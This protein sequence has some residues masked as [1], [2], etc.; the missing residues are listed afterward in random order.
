LQDF[1]ERVRVD[2]AAVSA[3]ALARGADDLRPIVD[4]LART[5]PEAGA[6]TTFEL[7]T[8]LALAHYAA[9]GCA[10]AVV[11][12]GLGGRYDATNA[13]D[14]QVSVITAISHDHTREL[15]TRLDSI[16][17]EKSG[18]LR[19]GRVAV[20]APQRPIVRRALLLA[21]AAVGAPAREVR[22]AGGEAA[23]ALT[24]RGE[25]QRANLAAALAAADALAEDGVPY[26]AS[27]AP[28]GLRRLRWPGRF[29]I[30]PGTPTTVLDGA[31]N[32]GSADALAA[33]LR[34]EFP[35]RRVRFVIGLMADKDARGLLRPLLPLARSVEA[36]RV[37]SPRALAPRELVR[38]C[39]GVKARAHDEPADAIAAARRD[40][41]DRDIVCVTG[42]LALIGRARDILGL[43]VAERLW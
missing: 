42:S 35:R 4:E 38:L 37:A 8:V 14:P 5:A 31:H 19:P 15:G 30:V 43:P 25:H 9:E 17:L 7:T 10:V 2:G 1:R 26:R 24:L 12:V 13:T 40:A 18:I 11:E 39:R 28:K 41:G 3:A 29:E 34:R 23:E 32:D 36:T 21:C 6:P 22:P 16:A 20:I 33:T 27:A